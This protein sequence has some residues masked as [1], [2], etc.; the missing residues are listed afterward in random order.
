MKKLISSIAVAAL[1]LGVY[2]QDVTETEMPD[3]EQLKAEIQQEVGVELDQLPVAV[4]DR[5]AEARKE[6]VEARKQLR[7][8]RA[9]GKTPEEI[10]A[11]VEQNRL[12]ATERLEQAIRNMEG[13]SE[14]VRAQV[15]QAKAEVQKR[16]EEKTAELKQLQEQ[17]RQRI[18]EGQSNGE[19]AGSSHGGN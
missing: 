15:E 14:Q 10:R 2:A 1:A 9:Q 5:L 11:L 16:L 17:I 8:M 13:V 6:M 4:Q 18:Q 3:F 12:E 7:D 19:N